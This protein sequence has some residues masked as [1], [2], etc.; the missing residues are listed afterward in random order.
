MECCGNPNIEHRL[1]DGARHQKGRR[2]SHT[3]QKRS[4]STRAADTSREDFLTTLFWGRHPVHLIIPQI[5]LVFGMTETDVLFCHGVIWRILIV[6]QAVLAQL[7]VSAQEEEQEQGWI[8]ACLGVDL[9]ERSLHPQQAAAS[10]CTQF[11][12]PQSQ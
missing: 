4:E 3:Q 6:C 9:R 12:H 10:S 11:P 5:Y 1:R 8:R 7:L 2:P